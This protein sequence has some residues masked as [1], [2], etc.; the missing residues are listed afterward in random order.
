MEGSFISTSSPP[1]VNHQAKPSIQEYPSATSTSTSDILPEENLVS[2]DEL[3]QKLI[4]ENVEAAR[5]NL[6]ALS[7]ILLKRSPNM[8]RQWQK[9][10]FWVRDFKLY[11]SHNE[12]KSGKFDEEKLSQDK[13]SVSISL[14]TVHSITEKPDSED[15]TEFQVRARDPRNGQMRT[16]ILKAESVSDRDRWVRGLNAHRDCL[17]STLRWA[18][19]S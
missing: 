12:V 9:R 4:T 13:K 5:K 1:P 14:V 15:S 2:D 3:A 11:Y 8:L 7:G 16:Y 19:S 10:H 17:M 18:S 6:P